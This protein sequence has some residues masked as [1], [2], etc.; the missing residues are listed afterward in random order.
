M[1]WRRRLSRLPLGG[2]VLV[3]L[4][5]LVALVFSTVNF[6]AGLGHVDVRF[7]SGSPGGNYA[8]VI[9]RISARAAKRDGKIEN[10]RTQGSVDN[11]RRLV[12]GCD[13]H[14]ALVQ[15]GTP[16][17]EEGA[18]KLQLIGRVPRGET[19]FIIGRD[20]ERLTKF[21]D[22]KGMKIGLGPQGS[23]TDHLGRS[24]LESEDLKPLGLQLSNHELGDQVDRLTSG[25]LD[26][27]V[28]VLDEEAA[29]IRTAIRD[30]KLQLVS[31]EQMDVIPTH[32]PVLSLGTIPA[33]RYD[34]LAVIPERT[35]TVL[36][37]DTLVIGN[38]CASRSVEIGVLRVLTEELPAFGAGEQRGALRRSAVAR[39]FLADGPGF[40][41]Q[42]VPW[43]VDIMP[44]GNWFYIVMS[45]SVLMNAMTLWH[46]VRLWRVDANRDKAFQIVRDVFGEQLTPAELLVLEP[47]DEL[48]TPANRER[49]DGAIKK[50]DVLRAT[51]RKHENSMLVP[52]GAEWM[53]RYE[54]EQMEAL[55][56]ALRTFRTKLGSA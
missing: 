5:A 45:I 33:G 31:L 53:Y 28:F 41:D 40:A 10:V 38:G 56:T 15:G 22:L 46:K 16:L 25:A 20:A 30:R 51:T 34:A 43:L 17:P 14:F 23:G 7:L 52:L 12:E 26:L 29:L 27:G 32:V 35:H 9:D 47:S 4:S 2:I 36:R 44:L 55:L 13:A 42:Y 50:L 48:R 6:G 39:E 49:I 1:Q 21:A 3:L 11:V 24:V 18:D 37:V 19:L 54:E 8:A